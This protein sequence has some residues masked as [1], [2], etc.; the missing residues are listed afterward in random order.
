MLISETYFTSKYHFTIP[1]HQVCST[2]HPD[3]T[4]HGGT[5]ILVKFSIAFYE[6]LPHAEAELQ[7]TTIRVKGPLRDI[8]IAAVYCPLDITSKRC[9]SN[10]S[11]ELSARAFRLEGI[12][13]AK[14]R[15]GDHD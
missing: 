6:Q 13:T 3:G 7:A 12:L 5:A 9:I 1:D 10:P 15:Y 2:N 4:A 11:S 14:I 8:S